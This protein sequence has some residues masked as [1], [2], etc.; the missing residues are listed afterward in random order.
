MHGLDPLF[1][2]VSRQ[3]Q[4]ESAWI[5]FLGKTKRKWLFLFLFL[6]SYPCVQG[7]IYVF[8]HNV[9]KKIFFI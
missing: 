9:L 4:C 1:V 7:M 6:V 8:N 2:T 5:D 3:G